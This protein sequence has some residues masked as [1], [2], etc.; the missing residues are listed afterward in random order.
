MKFH[1][2]WEQYSRQWTLIEKGFHFINVTNP[3][4]IDIEACDYLEQLAE[5]R[6]V[7]K[8]YFVLISCQPM[9]AFR[10]E[11]EPW[12]LSAALSD[13]LDPLFDQ[14]VGYVVNQRRASISGIQ[15]HLRI[16][17]NR[18]AL[19]VEQMEM[20]GIVSSPNHEGQRVVL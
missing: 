19:I 20:Q 16:G 14:A 3:L 10:E 8:R 5:S 17:Y 12:V 6:N 4:D 13:E 11:N 9:P 15:R 7:E 18:A 2:V 1:L